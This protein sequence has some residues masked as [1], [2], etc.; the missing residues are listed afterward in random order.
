MNIT[1]PDI[2][3]IHLD[4]EGDSPDIYFQDLLHARQ[5]MN[6]CHQ[7]L[8]YLAERKITSSIDKLKNEVG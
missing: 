1:S 4:E 3:F 6:K 7:V 2:I 5:W 8:N